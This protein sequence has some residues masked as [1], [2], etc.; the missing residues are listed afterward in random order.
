MCKIM[1]WRI[2][3]NW[4]ICDSKILEKLSIG[5]WWNNTIVHPYNWILK[6]IKNEDDNTLSWVWNTT[7]DTLLSKTKA[8][9]S[10]EINACDKTVV[11][12]VTFPTDSFEP[13]GF[14]FY[15]L[16]EFLVLSFNKI[17]IIKLFEQN[18]I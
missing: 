18:Y 2:I 4:T 7:K 1:T 16:Y 3:H 15:Q 10:G 8:A 13:F 14:L 17:I 6:I 11:G 9:S 5:N 12:R